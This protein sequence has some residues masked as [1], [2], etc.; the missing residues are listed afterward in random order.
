MDKCHALETICFSWWADG[1]WPLVVSVSPTIQ[2]KY[3]WQTLG[4]Y[5]WGLIC[6]S[7]VNIWMNRFRGGQIW[8]VQFISQWRRLS[9]WEAEV[10]FL[11]R[12]LNPVEG[13]WDNTSLGCDM[14]EQTWSMFTMDTDE[15]KHDLHKPSFIFTFCSSCFYL[16]LAPSSLKTYCISCK[17]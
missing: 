14:L 13:C 5:R 2:I 6:V 11:P 10:S 4:Y 7:A 1:D 15:N 17:Y 12:R 8:S 9:S 3:I 16:R